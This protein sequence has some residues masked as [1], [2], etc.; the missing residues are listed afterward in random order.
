M[1]HRVLLAAFIAGGLLFPAHAQRVRPGRN[2][3]PPKPKTEPFA[4]QG[5]IRALMPGRIQILTDSTQNWIVFVDP[6]A[7]IRV[8]GTA[9]P[10][11]LKIGMFIRFTAEVDKRGL[12]KNQLE[13]LTIFTPSQ[14]VFP[15]IWPEGQEPA[16]DKPAEGKPRFGTG[17]GGPAAV[18]NAPASNL[19]TVAGCITG[20][21]KGLLT[22][23]AGRAVVRVQVAVDAKI[24]V[25]I[26]DYSV[27]K[28]GDKI[29][30]TRGKMFAGRVG[31]AQAQELAIKLSKPLALPKKKPTR[32]K[33]PAKKSPA[34]PRRGPDQT[35]NGSAP[36]RRSF[37]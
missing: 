15:G 2:V 12:V 24:D 5:T 34:R 13:Q 19:Y 3:Q 17:V 11:F 32:K 9:E 10:D 36:S 31:I 26:S 30:V 37:V 35:L 22:V 6:K 33:P 20:S 18:G 25:D 21:R 14:R 28:P 23:N 4:A 8:T 16:A 1:V 7:I 27:A 29:S